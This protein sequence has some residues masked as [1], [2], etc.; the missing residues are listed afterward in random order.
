MNVI[1]KEVVPKLDPTNMGLQ[2]GDR[3][4]RLQL[5]HFEKP[6]FKGYVLSTFI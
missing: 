5:H 2:S 6:V 1:W 4:G 3:W